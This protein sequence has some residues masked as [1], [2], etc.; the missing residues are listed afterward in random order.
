MGPRF[1]VALTTGMRQGE[2][3]GIVGESG[4]GKS[5]LARAIVRLTHPVSGRIVIDGEDI[6]RLG[7][8][9]LRRLRPRIQMIFQ[10]P[11]ASL[12]P[13]MTVFDAI[14]EP[15]RVHRRL[16]SKDLAGET[17]L[18]RERIHLAGTI[19]RRKT[20]MNPHGLGEGV[21]DGRARV[22]RGVGIL[23]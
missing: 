13:R 23:G 9:A 12:N 7:E 19:L 1:T 22:Q 4:C 15:I 20:A 8:A 5:T 18:V 6:A 17:H 10:D 21:K 14:A 16:A 3:L 2:V 11:Y